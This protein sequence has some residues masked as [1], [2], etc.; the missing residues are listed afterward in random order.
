MKLKKIIQAIGLGLILS[1]TSFAIEDEKSPQLDQAVA[2]K[3]FIKSLNHKRLKA[4]PKDIASPEYFLALTQLINDQLNQFANYNYHWS[5][6]TDSKDKKSL[7]KD[8]I[9]YQY[10]CDG[11][12]P[13]KDSLNKF[14]IS[15]FPQKPNIQ[16]LKVNLVIADIDKVN[17]KPVIAQHGKYDKQTGTYDCS[18][19]PY[20]Q[21]SLLGMTEDYNQ[22]NPHAKAYAAINGSYF[23]RY[24]PTGTF[25]DMNCVWKS[26]DQI[27]LGI[28]ADKVSL[29]TDFIGDGLTVINSKSFANNCAA[30]DLKEGRYP[31]SM[32]KALPSPERATFIVSKNNKGQNQIEIK[33]LSV[34]EDRSYPNIVQALGAGPMLMQNGDYQVDWQGIPGAFQYSANPGLAIALN[35]VNPK[36]QKVVFFSVDGNNWKTGV[37]TFELANL[38]NNLLSKELNYK[39]TSM[40]ALDR[41]GS[42]TMITCPK[43]ASCQK[44]S[45][46]GEGLNNPGRL[47]FNGLIITKK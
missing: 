44:I 13:K 38:M 23:Y 1:S 10:Y 18:K 33:N 43:G 47:I 34:G 29:T 30:Y 12:W 6:H 5:C 27:L 25:Y 11:Q 22:Q 17:I 40:M 4:L 2:Q 28:T 7:G 19:S 39:V 14:L 26:V 20:C 21:Q 36:S 37:F 16:N 31:V 35:K 42:T 8:V 41:G 45:D 32:S 15:M 3:A 46:A 24:S 9:E